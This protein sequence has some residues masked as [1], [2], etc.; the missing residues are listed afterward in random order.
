M[1]VEALR[2]AADGYLPPGYGGRQSGVV[3]PLI[4]KL[5]FSEGPVGIPSTN[6][7]HNYCQPMRTCLWLFATEH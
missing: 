3:P 2:E 7:D 4:N 1:L 6:P 5:A